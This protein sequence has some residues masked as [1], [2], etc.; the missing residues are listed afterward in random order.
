MSTVKLSITLIWTLLPEVRYVE[1]RSRE[2]LD[3]STEAQHTQVSVCRSKTLIKHQKTEQKTSALRMKI[4]SKTRARLE[5][6]QTKRQIHVTITISFAKP[7]V[8]TT[9]KIGLA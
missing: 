1:I 6:N 9:V 2:Q 5:G 7:A 8:T 3:Q 4:V